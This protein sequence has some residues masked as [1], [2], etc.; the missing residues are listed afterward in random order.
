MVNVVSPR[1]GTL[2]NDGFLSKSHGLGKS[3]ALRQLKNSI[4]IP[5]PTQP[6]PSMIS[7]SPLDLALNLASMSHV[8]GDGQA[9]PRSASFLGTM[10]NA[11][12]L[13]LMNPATTVCCGV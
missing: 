9:F 13:D 2:N 5:S 10:S 3:C 11:V 12:A 7:V 8:R 6:A 4:A 1:S